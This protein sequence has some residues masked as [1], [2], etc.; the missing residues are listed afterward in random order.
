MS[1]CI[2]HRICKSII[3]TNTLFGAMTSS[4]QVT[5]PLII[6]SNNSDTW[7]WGYGDRLRDSSLRHVDARLQ[8]MAPTIDLFPPQAET[9]AIDGGT[10]I[11]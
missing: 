11:P 5:A 10:M 6:I 1:R 8:S 3:T 4:I 9:T 2:G 7:Y